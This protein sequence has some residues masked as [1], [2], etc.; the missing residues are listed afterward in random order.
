M[1]WS[2]FKSICRLAANKYQ[3]GSQNSSLIR[4]IKIKSPIP[5]DAPLRSLSN[6]EI[7]FQICSVLVDIFAK[8]CVWFR[9]NVGTWVEINESACVLAWVDQ[10]ANLINIAPSPFRRQS[11][12]GASWVQI[13]IRKTFCLVTK[14]FK[15]Q[16]RENTSPENHGNEVNGTSN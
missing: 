15:V 14:W 1:L 8:S 12:S 7:R 2:W 13:L 3:F 10:G 6:N 4:L 11:S 16:N 9:A 5:A